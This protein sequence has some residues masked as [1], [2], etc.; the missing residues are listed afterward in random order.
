MNAFSPD[1]H[2]QIIFLYLTGGCTSLCGS[3]P[4][5]EVCDHIDDVQSTKR[6]RV[7]D[8]ALIHLLDEF[9]EEGSDFTPYMRNRLLD[10][11]NCYIEANKAFELKKYQS[12]IELYEE[13]IQNGRKPAMALQQAREEYTKN[14]FESSERY[15]AGLDWI[16]TTFRN[17]CTSRLQLGDIDGARRDA[18][19]AT[20]FSQNNDAASHECLADVCKESKDALGEYQAVK[21][22]I[23]QYGV[24]EQIYSS[25][26]PGIDAVARAEAAKIR[27]NAEERKRELGFRLAKLERELK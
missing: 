26:M 19:A 2:V 24:V 13:A 14:A 1:S 9:T 27:G 20:V 25:P 22:A 6:K 11:Y 15:P 7:S 4:I 8:E 10:G 16:V 23:E 12:A 17:S 21:S 5:V 18:F 3:G